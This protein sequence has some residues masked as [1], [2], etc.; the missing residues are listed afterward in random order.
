M[1][2]PL[3]VIHLEISPKPDVFP[4]TVPRTTLKLNVNFHVPSFP[5]TSCTLLHNASPSHG[6]VGTLQEDLQWPETLP[7]GR[8]RLAAERHKF[9]VLL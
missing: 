6:T 3:D 7:V 8:S 2:T 9:Q 4:P 5:M 1:G